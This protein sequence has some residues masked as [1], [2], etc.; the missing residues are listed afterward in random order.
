VLQCNEAKRKKR[1]RRNQVSSLS[2]KMR[3][4]MPGGGQFLRAEH[5]ACDPS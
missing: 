5:L 4:S 2:L 1:E 3:D